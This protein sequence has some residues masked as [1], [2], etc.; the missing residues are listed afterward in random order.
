MAAL[1]ESVAVPRLSEAKRLVVKILVLDDPGHQA[2]VVA[3]KVESDLIAVGARVHM[4][5]CSSSGPPE[6]TTCT[7][8]T[9]LMSALTRTSLFWKGLE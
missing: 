8:P 1:T 3:A 6:R 4:E 7:R 9:S 5:T 2:E